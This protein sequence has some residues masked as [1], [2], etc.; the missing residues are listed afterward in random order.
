MTIHMVARYRIGVD[1]AFY[2]VFGIFHGALDRIPGA[3]GSRSY[4]LL[5][6]RDV[7]QLWL[8][9]AALV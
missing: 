8:R 1:G 4:A 7:A 9:R 3:Y 5:K 6:T 2:M